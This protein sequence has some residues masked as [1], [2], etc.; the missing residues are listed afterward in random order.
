MKTVR[1]GCDSCSAA[2][3]N[4]E[5]SE[6]SDAHKQ[7]KVMSYQELELYVREKHSNEWIDAKINQI[8]T[9]LTWDKREQ[10]IRI[11]EM[12]LNSCPEIG[13]VAVCFFAPPYYPA[14]NS[15]EDPLVKKII[16]RLKNDATVH[17]DR[18]LKHRHFFN[19]ISDLSYV[20]QAKSEDNAEFI[21]K[22]MPVWKRGYSIPFED[23]SQLKAPVLNMGSFGKDPHLRSERLH[24]QSAFIET[25][26]L[27]RT[28]IDEIINSSKGDDD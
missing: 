3:L 16:S 6:L 5:E 27:I 19:G 15:S 1:D 4:N 21:S 7:I 28:V 22:N 17:P 11:T 18:K 8:S 23:I 13:P 2:L 14:V 12:L 9:H 20:V 10:S 26:K 25:P 24:K